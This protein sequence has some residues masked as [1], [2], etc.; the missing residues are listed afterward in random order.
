MA[1]RRVGA[2]GDFLVGIKISESD[3][4]IAYTILNSKIMNPIIVKEVKNPIEKYDTG[5]VLAR[6]LNGENITAWMYFL[7]KFV[8]N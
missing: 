1:A 4:M 2:Q 7:V 6:D 5:F 3:E 8:L